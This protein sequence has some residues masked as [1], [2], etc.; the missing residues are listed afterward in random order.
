MPAPA[1][2][3]VTARLAVLLVGDRRSYM[4]DNGDGLGGTWSAF[5]KYVFEPLR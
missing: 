3:N 5:E 2:R 1:G 4:G